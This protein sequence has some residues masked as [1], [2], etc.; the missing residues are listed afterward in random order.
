M[1]TAPS[2]G[3]GD[4]KFTASWSPFAPAGPKAG[5]RIQGSEKRG[6][7]RSREG[8]ASSRSRL[9]RSGPRISQKGSRSAFAAA[10]LICSRANASGATAAQLTGQRSCSKAAATCKSVRMQTREHCQP[11][12]DPDG[13]GAPPPGVSAWPHP[14]AAFGFH[15][16]GFYTFCG[17]QEAKQK[18]QKRAKKQIVLLSLHSGA[19]GAPFRWIDATAG[20]KSAA[21][22]AEQGS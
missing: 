19:N 20:R 8:G 3:S 6:G 16:E 5:I 18:L 11:Q 22:A 4:Q 21:A 7:L 9:D 1:T 17:L 15:A 2:A 13:G 12:T 10:R 14:P